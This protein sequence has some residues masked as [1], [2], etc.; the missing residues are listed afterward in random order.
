MCAYLYLYLQEYLYK[1]Q[2]SAADQ[3]MYE[4]MPGNRR[5]LNTSRYLL[6]GSGEEEETGKQEEA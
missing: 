3:D 6:G 2:L 4:N 1:Q 5:G